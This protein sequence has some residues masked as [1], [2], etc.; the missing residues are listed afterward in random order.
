MQKLLYLLRSLRPRYPQAHLRIP[1]ALFLVACLLLSYR[2]NS[3]DLSAQKINIHLAGVSVKT[4]LQE[5]QK[6]SGIKFV[7]GQEIN[8]YETLKISLNESGISV[9]QAIERVLQNTRLRYTQKGSNVMIDEKPVAVTP[10]RPANAPGYVSGKILDERG[11]P[12]PG[13]AVTIVEKQQGTQ[14]NLEGLY[15]YRL[16]AGTYTLEI[17][18]LGYQAQ[19]IEG[20]V[21]ADNQ[22]TPLNI[23]LKQETAGLKGV[24]VSSGYKKA[25]VAG[26]LAKQ[27]SAA[28]VS[29]GISAEEISRTPDKNIGESLKRISGVSTVDNRFVIVRGIGERYN[30]AV[31]DG[32]VLPSTEAQTRNFSFDLIPSSLV[33]NVIVSK[34]VTPD[35]NVSF[36]GGLVQVNTKDIPSQN[37]TTISAGT[38][39]NDQST[40]KEF[41]SHK[42][43]KY[44][45]LGFSDGHRDFPDQLYHTDRTAVPNNTLSNEEYQQKVAAQSKRFT[46]DNFT[47]YKY[48]AAPSQNYQFTIGRLW[49]L[50]T[51]RVNKLGFTGAIT[52]RNT[53][54]INEFDQQKR[55]DWYF[56]SNNYGAAYSFNTTI[57]ALVNIGLQ[58]GEN[59]FSFR[60][61]YTRL[62]DNTLVR[63]IG[64]EQ[65]NGPDQ[66]AQ[67]LPPGRIQEVDD[68][69]YTTL[70]QNKLNGQHHLGKLSLEWNLA[71]TSIDR[72]EKDLSIATSGPYLIGKN[73]EYFYFTSRESEPRI[74]PSSRHNYH[75][76][77]NHYSWSLDASLPF[78]VAGIRNTLKTGYFG[79]SRNAAFDWQIAALTASN[80]LTDSIRFVPVSEM[81]NPANFGPNGYNYNITGYLLDAF[82]G[83]STT[84]AG[85]LL[86]DSRLLPKLRL[87]WGVRAEYYKYTEIKN[88]LNQAGNPKDFKIPEDKT[89]QWLPSANLT[90]S[91][92]SDLNIR[93]A[94]STRV[95]RPELM[96]NSQFFKY[97]PYLAAP[98]G[99][100]GLTSTR[101]NSYDFKTEWFPGLGEIISAGAFYKN[102][103]NPI[104]LTF[105]LVNGNINYYQR[106]ASRG[107]V[108]G[109][110]FELR[111]NF[112]FIAV[113][114]KLLNNLT[115]YGNLTLQK[116]SV[117]ATYSIKNPEPGSSGNIDVEVKQDRTMYGQSPYLINAGLQYQDNRLGLNL[118]YN[119][120][121][122]K[123]YIVSSLLNQ[124]EYEAPREQVDAQISYKLFRKRLEVKLNAGNLLNSASMFFANIGSYK[125]NPG[126]ELDP[127]K[128]YSL[129]EGFSDNYEEG[130]QIRLRQKFGRTYS[131]TLTYTF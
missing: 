45:Y 56:G 55:N 130:D 90:Y 63:T 101:V 109:L 59:R 105:I 8:K 12:L 72:K 92:V 18:Y 33:D 77:E 27:K 44:D 23:A 127:T 37:F 41:L 83:K 87:L 57:G 36:G 113:N 39:Y 99:N 106:N 1:A 51:S 112:G 94:I 16:P 93:A 76:K 28:E 129:K 100:Q 34:T 47:L 70:L 29:N 62:Y 14:T 65:D 102:F 35:M 124:I 115:A 60:N 126:F 50:D 53:Q 5:I 32:V 79:T 66:V 38:S 86:F 61:T 104:E 13:A 26:L 31:L 96:D 128:A 78:S 74:N 103:D 19:R 108:Y 69:T 48:K 7:H 71:R 117:R 73:Y 21:I 75:N 122:R 4:A 64:Y 58:M 120:S 52:Y 15:E 67:G 10:T 118:A 91:P 22:N 85:Y 97:N 107:K 2:G 121:G 81:A 25:S 88:G 30:A 17:S 116:S 6:L 98:F 131:A 89:W 49:T 123:T 125:P 40:G 46:N 11:Q 3:Q 95:I 80:H 84:Q 20:V 82:E 110:E 111:K 68:P 54:Q 24:M 9:K 43:G 114:N 42:R 119:K